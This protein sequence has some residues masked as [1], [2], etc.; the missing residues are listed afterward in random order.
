[1]D[2]S[3]LVLIPIACSLI[4]VAAAVA[5]VFV[6]RRGRDHELQ[7]DVN[8]LSRLVERIDKETRR[9]RMRRVRAGTQVAVVETEGFPVPPG[10]E[11]LELAQ[12]T[13]EQVAL[14]NKEQLRRRV[15]AAR[16]S[17]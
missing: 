8:E 3:Y 2:T 7:G 12:Q 9:E 4:S 10:A 13:P 11:S 16:R 17:G 6:V 15:F 1:V 14:Q 5:A